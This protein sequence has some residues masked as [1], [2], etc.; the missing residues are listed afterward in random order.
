MLTLA[1]GSSSNGSPG[2]AKGSRAGS[3]RSSCS[4]FTSGHCSFTDLPK[5]ERDNVRDDELDAF[6]MLA[7]MM[8][9]YD[10]EAL[11]KAIEN[12]TLTEVMCNDQAV[13]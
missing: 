6:K 8:M 13:S 7:A 12:G 11:A 2:K 3:A 9:A 5:N 4:E 10:D 1:V